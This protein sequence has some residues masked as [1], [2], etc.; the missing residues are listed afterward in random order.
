MTEQEK[1]QI[2]KNCLESSELYIMFLN[3]MLE[4]DIPEEDK[5]VFLESR[6]ELIENNKNILALFEKL[7]ANSSQ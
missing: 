2:L 7:E 5:A 6:N 3:G 4:S 1:Y